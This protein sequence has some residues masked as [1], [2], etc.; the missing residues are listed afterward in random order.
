MVCSHNNI[1]MEDDVYLCESC[2]MRMTLMIAALNGHSECI[3][4]MIECQ[5]ADL[6]KR[7]VD[8][9]TALHLAVSSGHTDSLKV[10]LAYDQLAETKKQVIDYQDKDGWTAAMI[11]AAGD[12][13]PCLTT[14]LTHNANLDIVNED[15][16]NALLLAAVAGQE[17]AVDSILRHVASA[18]TAVS[19]QDM[20]G[21]T[22]LML[23]AAGGHF[24]CVQRLIAAG[25]NVQAANEEG[26]TPVMLASLNGHTRCLK[27]LLENGAGLTTNIDGTTSLMLAASCG[28]IECISLLLSH[29]A[30]VTDQNNEGV[31]ALMFATEN[32]HVECEKV[33]SQHA[34]SGNK[35]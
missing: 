1:I 27:Y 32:G 33:L 20:E 17:K 13:V 6:T 9:T 26:T 34:S 5:Q 35:S 31:S 2:R 25:S 24:A 4:H 30:D 8:G 19:V 18:E 28:H 15:G 29:G 22:P 12:M 7:N 23:A 3:S 21:M 16:R 11:A 10:L 14:L